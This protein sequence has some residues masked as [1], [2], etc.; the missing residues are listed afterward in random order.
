M[1]SRDAAG[2][3]YVTRL[4]NAAVT[5]RGVRDRNSS[6]CFADEIVQRNGIV[7]KDMMKVSRLRYSY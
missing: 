1:L 6:V 2:N 4:T 7:G 3:V 5:V